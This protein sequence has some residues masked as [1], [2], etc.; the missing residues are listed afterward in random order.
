MSITVAQ[1]QADQVWALSALFFAVD[2]VVALAEKGQWAEDNFAVL[3][4]SLQRFN[5][6]TVR[7]FYDNPSRLDKGREDLMHYFVNASNDAR[8]SYALRLMQVARRLGSNT[9]LMTVLAEGLR[10]TAAQIGHFGLLHDNIFARYSA[11]YQKTA[12]QATSRI[13]I[14]GNPHYLQQNAIADRLRTVLLCGVRAAALWQANGGSRWQLMFGRAG[15]VAVAKQM[16][17]V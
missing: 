9:A 14:Y 16:E 13:R 7:D 11:L 10:Q 5:C 4:P 15:I 1:E 3:M 8:L 12:S 2:G 6:E 17:M